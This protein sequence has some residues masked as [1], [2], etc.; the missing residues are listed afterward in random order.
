MSPTEAIET[1]SEIRMQVAGQKR[2]G[3][4][5]LARGTAWRKKLAECRVLE[6]IDRNTT[7]G[8]LLSEE[9]MA[10]LLET[11]SYFEAEAERAQVAY[12]IETRRNADDWKAGADLHRDIDR[13][14][15]SSLAQMKAAFDDD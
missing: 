3:V 15:E 13:L 2:I 7:A 1:S 14:A 4:T 10:S 11:I 8:W 9:G 6:V 12:L 5:E